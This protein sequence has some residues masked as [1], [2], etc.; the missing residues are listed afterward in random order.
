[1]EGQDTDGIPGI[2]SI[3]G[4]L[5]TGTAAGENPDIQGADGAKIDSI[6]YL[7]AAGNSQTED[8]SDGV[9]HTVTTPTG[10]LTVNQDGTWSFTPIASFD[11]DNNLSGDG[12]DSATNASFTYVL[13]DFDGDVSTGSQTIDVQDGDVP[14]IDNNKNTLVKVYEGDAKSTFNGTDDYAESDGTADKQHT[15]M[16]THKLDFTKGSDDAYISEVSWDMADGTTATKQLVDAQ[17]NIVNNSVTFVDVDTAGNDDGKGTLTVY[18]D[19][20]WEYTPPSSYVHPNPPANP[21][22][23]INKFDTTFTYKVHDID[24]DEVSGGSQTIQVDDTIATITGTTDATL[25]EENLSTGT[26]PDVPAT[27]QTGT[28]TVDAS[29]LG[30]SYDIKFDSTQTDSTWTDVDTIN[31]PGPSNTGGLSSNGKPIEYQVSA[32]GHTLQAVIDKGTVNVT[33]IFEVTITNPTGPNPGYTTTLYHDLDHE[34]ALLENGNLE[35]DFNITLTDDDGDKSPSTFKVS[36]V[37]DAAVPTTDTLVVDEEGA[38]G[39]HDTFEIINTNANATPANTTITTQGTYGYAEILSNGQLKYTPS[40]ATDGITSE[41]TNYSGEDTVVYDYVDANGAHHVTTVTVTVNPLS[42][43]P[44]LTVDAPTVNTDEDTAV[45]LGLNVPIVVDDHDQNGT[46]TAG[47][48]PERLSAIKLSGITSGAELIFG[49]STYT[50]TGSPITIVISDL[51]EN[52]G[53]IG[54]THNDNINNVTGTLTMTKAEFEAMQINPV[55]QSGTNMTV[56]MEVTSYEVDNN[57]DPLVGVAGATSTTQVVVDVHA[58][59]DDG[60]AIIANN[61]SGNED[62]WMQVD[63]KI[64]ITP[65]AD[66]DGSEKY[67]LV[68]DGANLPVG[69]LYYLGTPTP[70]QME[71]RSIGT[72]ASGGFTVTVNDPNNIPPIYIMTPDNDSN[73]VTGLSVTVNVHDTDADSTPATDVVKSDTATINIAVSPVANDLTIETTDSIGN[74]DTLIDLNL[75]FTIT[76]ILSVPDN[77]T[78]TSVT[79]SDIPDGAKIYKADGTTLVYENTSGALGVIAIDTTS[80]PLSDIEGYRILPPG[81]SSKDFT[82]KVGATTQDK[83][84]GGGQATDTTGVIGP[85]DVDV[86]V[87]PIAETNNDTNNDGST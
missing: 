54:D 38:T 50:S 28:I 41:D 61:V 79:I 86:E 43:A 6:T 39:S 16:I 62:A 26:V 57:G 2:D 18:V 81:H 68:F 48:N 52:D 74:E 60:V 9:N 75:S 32:D 83:D 21:G 12:T 67:E 37:D 76:D 70:A 4:N 19:G 55:P 78:V 87:K 33:T 65:T 31:P 11:H 71:D 44:T 1:I 69:T 15:S 85:I 30:G 59:T 66:T 3:G 77:E 42:D 46:G 47:D 10:S 34:T 35:F 27:T 49:G 64:T 17:G 72:V 8:L 29:K 5:L 51:D 56:T 22:W 23:D 14:T 25:K 20:T 80:V 84:D 63:D 82:L 7:D 45:A 13:K 36:I 24:N 53:G 40:V 58:K 73:D